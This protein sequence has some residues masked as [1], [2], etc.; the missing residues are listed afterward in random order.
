MFFR[1]TGFC[2]QRLVAHSVFLEEGAYEVVEAG[3]CGL[4]EQVLRADALGSDVVAHDLNGIARQDAIPS[5]SVE[6][7][8]D[9][10][11][12]D[13]GRPGILDSI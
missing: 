12:C 11:E 1:A 4:N 5:C 3:D 9:E 6:G 10:D 2:V 7:V 8:K 13:H